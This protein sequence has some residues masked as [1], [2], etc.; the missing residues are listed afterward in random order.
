MHE[1]IP[2]IDLLSEDLEKLIANKDKHPCTRAAAAK[3]YKLLNKYYA[4]TDGSIMYRL[5][6]SMFS[7]HFL[8]KPL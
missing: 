7:L 8:S 6:M 4:R 3:G 5:C 1:V 2:I